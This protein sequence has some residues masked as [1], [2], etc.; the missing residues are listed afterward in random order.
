MNMMLALVTPN[1]WRGT[2][3]PVACSPFVI[4]RGPGCH[5]RAHSPTVSSRHCALLV[6]DER[7]FMCAFEGNLGTFINDRPVE[8][9][10]EVHDLDSVKVGALRFTVRLV[11]SPVP[12]QAKPAPASLA[13]SEEDAATHLL[14]AIDEEERSARNASAADTGFPLACGKSP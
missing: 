9:E 12:Q 5:L 6:R 4:G 13:E 7:V 2:V 1:K 3:V 8:G 14:L 11:A 10:Q